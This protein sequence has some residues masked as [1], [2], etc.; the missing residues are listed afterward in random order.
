MKKNLLLL[1]SLLLTTAT[2]SQSI[3]ALVGYK[4]AEIDFTLEKDL[5]YGLG[6]SIIDSDQV[7]K[8]A[9]TNDRGNIH[10][11]TNSLTPAIFMLVGGKIETVSM[12]CKLG[13]TYL[14]QNIN[15]KPDDQNFYK[16]IG[17]QVGYRNF[18]F[19]FD[20]CNS[21]MVGY[22]INLKQERH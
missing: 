18:I 15:N 20:S 4:S 6:F 11:A 2:R 8:R 7:A 3:T 21:V 10:Q 12:M 1:L 9:T 14:Q 19:N 13:M 5:T 22:K 16:T 17:V